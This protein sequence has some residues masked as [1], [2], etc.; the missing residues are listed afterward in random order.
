MTMTDSLADVSGRIAAIKARFTALQPTTAG[1]TSTPF[2]RVLAAATLDPSAPSSTGSAS[3]GSSSS[4]AA[5]LTGQGVVDDASRYLGVPYVWGG[6][7]P[8][9]GLDCS[10]L[11]Q[12]TYGDLGIDLPRVAADQAKMGTPVASLA[13]ARPGDLVAFGSPVD[14]IGIYAGD[15]KMVV[16]PHKGDV[17][18]VE[19]ISMTPTA[20]RRILPQSK[21]PAQSI[22]GLVLGTWSPSQLGLRSLSGLSATGL[23]TSSGPGSSSYDD[24]FA[25]AGARYG[26]SP[27]LLSAVAKNESGY[28]P[29][30]VSPAG[31]QGLMQ[32][33]PSTAQGLGV[34]PLDPA[35][36]IDGAARLLAG[37]LQKFG[38]VDLAVAAYNAGG[39]AV[40]RYGG[41]PPFPETQNYVRRVLADAGVNA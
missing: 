40:T 33:M 7:D 5:G 25:A 19:Q 11:V 16:A 29:T 22:G 2:S 24:L 37:H 26:V 4:G 13:E 8:S 23:S 17:V 28:D 30:A 3:L 12:R 31:A 36:A 32:L 38:S 10:G 18:K 21:S 34:D 35:Q 15:G 6:T 20:I 41:I 39:G 1:A 9:I 14:H 27:Q